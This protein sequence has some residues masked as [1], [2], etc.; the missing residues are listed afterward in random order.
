MLGIVSCGMLVMMITG[1]FDLSVGAVGATASVATAYFSLHTGLP[2]AIVAGL[3]VGLIVGL[4][5]GVIIAK[6]QINAFMTTF[7]MASIV[8]GVIF[9]VTSASPITSDAGWLTTV[10]FGQIADVPYA[11]ILFLGVAAC[12]WLLLTQTKWGHYLYAVGSNRQ[13][14]FLS[15]V[16]VVSTQLAAFVFGGVCAALGGL[17][18]LG[19]SA[20]GQP[21]AATDWP[22]TAI[23]ICV[24]GGAS[25]TGGQGRVSGMIAATLL[26]TVVANGLNLVNV[27]S[28]VQ[29]AVTGLVILIAVV[30]DRFARKREASS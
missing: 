10:A 15:G 8:T 6:L 5:N 16:P 21:G 29:P 14:S 26:L 25:L 9:V 30:A 27:S 19:Q 23:A 20:L 24:I 3:A 4:A 11:F 2:V 28:Y 18:L 17:I 12:T 22:L 7:A 1:G 13:A